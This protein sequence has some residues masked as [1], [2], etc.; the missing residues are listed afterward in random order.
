MLKHL[1]RKPEALGSI[2]STTEEKEFYDKT[3]LW[4]LW[5]L[6]IGTPPNGYKIYDINL[7]YEI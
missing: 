4:Y 1:P 2:L 5:G 7:L 3:I 6:F